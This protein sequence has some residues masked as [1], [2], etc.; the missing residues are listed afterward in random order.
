MDNVNEVALKDLWPIMQEQILAGKKVRFG[1]KGTS[2]LPLIRQGVDTIVLEKAPEN[3]NKYDL[4][5]YLRDNGQFV[6]HRVVDKNENGYVMCGDNQYDREYDVKPSQILAIATGIYRGDK[7]VPFT[8][9]KYKAYCKKQV[10][11]KKRYRDYLRF[12]RFASK[13]KH[14]I[15]K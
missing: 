5:L 4:P 14:K 13:I 12:L 1:P 8:D 2:M 6:L 11:K 10:L 7:F 9:K 3:L 15:I